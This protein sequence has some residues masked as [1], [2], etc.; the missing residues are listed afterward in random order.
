MVISEKT[1]RIRRYASRIIFDTWEKRIND[2]PSHR[3]NRNY[4][5]SKAPHNSMGFLATNFLGVKSGKFSGIS[6]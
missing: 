5:I 1:V 3:I 6:S 2:T 4:G